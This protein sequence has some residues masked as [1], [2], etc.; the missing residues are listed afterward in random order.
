[1]P[2]HPDHVKRVCG[3]AHLTLRKLAE[4]CE[5]TKKRAFR[6]DGTLLKD[7]RYLSVVEREIKDLAEGFLL[8]WQHK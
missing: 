1:L 8:S 5:Q 4:L 3:I 6:F 2:V 7:H